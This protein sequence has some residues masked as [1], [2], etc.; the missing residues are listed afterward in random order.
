[1]SDKNDEPIF[2]EPVKTY[3]KMPDGGLAYVTR[4]FGTG[5]VEPVIFKD[6]AVAITEQEFNDKLIDKNKSSEQ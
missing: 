5:A 4:S 2:N 6:K 3:F 1:M